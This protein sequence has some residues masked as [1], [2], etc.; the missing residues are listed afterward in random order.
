[1]LSEPRVI[2]SEQSERSNLKGLP[3]LPSTD[4]Q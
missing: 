2:A 4:S 3:R 1:M